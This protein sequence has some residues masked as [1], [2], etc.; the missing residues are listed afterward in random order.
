M[1]AGRIAVQNLQEEDLDGDHRIEQRLDP[2]HLRIPAGGR[3][4]LGLKLAGPVQLELTNDI[5]DTSH[6][7]SYFP[8]VP[9]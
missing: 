6:D 4:C 7:E 1:F 9:F 8:Q 3:D 5:R 2:R